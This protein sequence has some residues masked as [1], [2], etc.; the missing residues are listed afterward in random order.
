ME[1]RQIIACY[2]GENGAITYFPARYENGI[3]TFETSH[4]S[5]FG[6]FASQAAAFT[7][8]NLDA[9]YMTEVEFAMANKFMSGYGDG[10]FALMFRSLVLCWLRFCTI[11]RGSPV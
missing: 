1:G 5:Q 8:V 11:W 9:W 3:V 4:F 7:D 6:V 10:R 2:F